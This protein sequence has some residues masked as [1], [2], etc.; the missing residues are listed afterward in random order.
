MVTCRSIARKPT[1]SASEFAQQYNDL[2]AQL[3]DLA[4]D[5]SFN[6]VNLLQG[7][8]L[9]VVFNELTGS[10]QS[11]LDIK[12]EYL[13]SDSLGVG[14]AHIWGGTDAFNPNPLEIDFQSDSDDGGLEDALNQLTNSLSSLRSTAAKFGSALSVVE[15]RSDFTKD[16]V[17]T[18]QSG[19]ADLTL[20]DTNEE[21]ANMLALQTRQQLSSTALSL[22]SQADQAVLRLF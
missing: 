10:Q 2:R 11:K 9:K 16:M 14:K 13:D 15:I 8:D 22:S 21:G 18:L 3:G 6:G 5:A 4:S 19:A 12:G 17:N 20:A 7:D 1:R